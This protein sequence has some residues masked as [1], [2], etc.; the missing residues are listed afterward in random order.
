MRSTVTIAVVA[1][2]GALLLIASAAAVPAAGAALRLSA[3]SGAHVV[4]ASGSSV[5]VAASAAANATGYRLYVSSRRSDVY[6]ANVRHART[7]SV[8][9]TPRMTVGR[10]RYATAPYYFR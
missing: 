6:V 4:A 3:P 7:S 9:R 1:A 2:T 8:Q 5:T 10:L